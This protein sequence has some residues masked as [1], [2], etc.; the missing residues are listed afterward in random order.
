MKRK[1]Q[2]KVVVMAITAMF[3]VTACGG[4]TSSKEQVNTDNNKNENA[5]QELTL[6][7]YYLEEER[8]SSSVVGS[9]LQMVDQWEAANPDVKLQ[10]QVMAQSDYSTKIQAQAAV[11]EVPYLPLYITMKPCGNP[12]DMIHSQTIGKTFMQQQKSSMKW[13]FPRYH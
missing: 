3:G 12:L 9:F 8:E 7:H 11:N 2:W 1:T 10:K 5:T 6:S 4:Q 13:E